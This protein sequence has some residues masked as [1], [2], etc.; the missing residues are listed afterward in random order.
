MTPVLDGLKLTFFIF[1]LELFDKAVK[2]IK[3]AQELISEGI[4]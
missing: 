1:S 2:T 3:N 4:L